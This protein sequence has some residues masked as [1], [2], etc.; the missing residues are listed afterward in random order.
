MHR[1][2]GTIPVLSVSLLRRS[3]DLAHP[4]LKAPTLFDDVVGARIHDPGHREAESLCRL[5]ID[6]QL[7]LRRQ[8][9]RQIGRLRACE[10]ASSIIANPTVSVGHAGSIA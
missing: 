3:V 1:G 2:C 4:G 7:E 10:N 6:D 5:E 9:D 8:L